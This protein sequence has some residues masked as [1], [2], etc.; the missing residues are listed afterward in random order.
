MST[1]RRLALTLLLGGTIA[2]SGGGTF[3]TAGIT[4]GSTV[5]EAPLVADQPGEP[6]DLGL[7]PIT[8]ASPE[9]HCAGAFPTFTWEPVPSAA[10]YAV[11]VLTTDGKPIWAWQ[12]PATTVVFGNHPTPPE[13]PAGGYQLTMSAK[14]FVVAYDAQGLP[15]ANSVLRP[16]APGDQVDGSSSPDTTDGRPRCGSD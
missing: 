11:V 12:G 6:L 13:E 10:S 14:W 2:V 8:L 4:A 1:V 15:V 16:V 5:P 3:A 7:P 9:M